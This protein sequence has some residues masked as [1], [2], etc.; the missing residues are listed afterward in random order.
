[1]QFFFPLLLLV[2][3]GENKR[4]FANVRDEEKKQKDLGDLMDDEMHTHALHSDDGKPR[5]LQVF[6]S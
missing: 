2:Y 1:M 3:F 5:Y 4:F 6:V